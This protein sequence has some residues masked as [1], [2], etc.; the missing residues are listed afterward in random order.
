MSNFVLGI[1]IIFP[2]FLTV[3]LGYWAKEKNFIDENFV[4]KATWLVFYMALPF[5]L[6]CDIKNTTIHSLHP[7]FVIYILLGTLLVFLLSWAIARIFISDRLKLSAF[8]HCCFR[9]N[10]LYIGLP[11]LEGIYQAP[12]MELIVILTAFGITLYNILGTIIL[13]FYTNQEGF[14]LKNF[15]IKIVKNPMI[16]SIFAG[17]LFHELHIPLYQGVESCFLLVGKM[18]T[19][20]SLIVI[21]GSLNLSR[22][23]SNNIFIVFMSAF[24][25]VALV[26][27]LMVPLGQLIG[28]SPVELVTS[29]VFW[30]TPCAVNCFV[31]TKE[32]GSDAE[33]A[34]K[35]VTL[36]L[37][38]AIFTYPVGIA[39][40]KL[41]GIL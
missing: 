5:K 27:L 14:Q 2:V 30:S 11:I 35:I 20:L 3:G 1:Q 24:T 32:M 18:A 21:G 37:L 34:G 15:L 8:V 38:L 39:L 29:Y 12:S 22:G 25:K 6:F 19:P 23:N 17:A 31:M 7:K 36:S 41:F 13:A 40:L 26:P 9:G 28:L 10:F 16:I 33:L 4:S